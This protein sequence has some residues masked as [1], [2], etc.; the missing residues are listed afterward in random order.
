M[1]PIALIGANGQLGSD[2][3]T[4]LRARGHPYVPLTRA[5]FDIRNHEQTSQS[6][7]AIE[8][9]VIVNTAAFHKIEACESDPEQAFSVNAIAVRNLALSAERLSAQLVHIS[10]DYVFD[11]EKASPYA[12]GDRPNPI[13]VYGT[14]KLSGEYFAGSLCT[15]HLVIRT[16]GLYGLAGSSGK[17]GNFVRTMIRL[18][19]QGGPVSVVTDQCLS[20]TYT[21]DLAAKICE[22]IDQ[23]AQGVFHVT[24]AESCSWFEFARTIFASSS[25]DV[26][27]RPISTS[28]T[29]TNVRRPRFSALSNDRLVRSGFEPLRPWRVALVEFLDRIGTAD[30]STQ[31]P[32]AT[33]GRA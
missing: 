33:G 27:L 4:Q 11:G 2:L 10:T 29:A 31:A 13:N 14:S 21:S 19:K 16:S 17:G 12:E 8:P 1:K 30:S 3:A 22:L 28:S 5:D 23:R 25:L 26:D 9:D 6:L 20:P 7:E 32:L 18:G 15:R 24:N